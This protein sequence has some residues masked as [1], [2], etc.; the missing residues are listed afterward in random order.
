MSRRLVRDGADVL[1][2]QSATSTFQDSWAPAQHASLAALRA[3]ESGRPVV[4]ATLTGVSAVYA[5]DGRRIGTPLGTDR[6]AAAV[7]ELPLTGTTTGYARFGDWPLYGALT[8][9][10]ALCAAEGMGT[11]RRPASTLRAPRARTARG[12]TGRPWR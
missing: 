7:H 10:A 4:H 6:S 5:P 8:V 11:L 1:I 2:T 12:S 9:L 3:A